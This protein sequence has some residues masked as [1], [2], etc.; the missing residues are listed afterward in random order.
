MKEEERIINRGII[1][2]ESNQKAVSKLIITT[3]LVTNSNDDDTND[4]MHGNDDDD[5][6]YYDNADNDLEK[7]ERQRLIEEKVF[8][9]SLMDDGI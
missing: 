1:S 2:K 9:T 8:V 3:T 5:T 7:G 4:E 6:N